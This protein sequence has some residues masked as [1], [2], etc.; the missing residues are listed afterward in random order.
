MHTEEKLFPWNASKTVPLQTC[1]IYAEEKSGGRGT[2]RMSRSG[3]LVQEKQLTVL[4]HK[5]VGRLAHA[6]LCI[7]KSSRKPAYLNGPNLQHLQILKILDFGI[8]F[9]YNVLAKF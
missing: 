9:S 8:Q 6:W 1:S 5:R 7:Q 3:K 2:V 4:V